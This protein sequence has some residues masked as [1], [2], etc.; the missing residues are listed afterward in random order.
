ME[1]Q[2]YRGEIKELDMKEYAKLAVDFLSYLPKDI[3]VHRITGEATEDELVAPYWCSPKYKME[4]LKAIEEEFQK[5]E[6]LEKLS[7]KV[8]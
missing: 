7:L 6:R 3:I 8:V 1:K 2:Y 5:R 4:V